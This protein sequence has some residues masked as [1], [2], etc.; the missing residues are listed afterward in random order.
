VW[1]SK[2]IGRK[3]K[4]CNAI[5]VSHFG[6]RR[7]GNKKN[8]LD[9][10]IYIVLSTQTDEAKYQSVY[11]N[12]KRR[13]RSWRK[14]ESHH[15]PEIET[16]LEPGGLSAIKADRIIS[17]LSTL[18][19]NFGARSLAMLKR[20]SDADAEKTLCSLPGVGI[21][22]ARCIM[23]YS[24]DRNVFPVDTHTFRTLDRLG[25][26]SY[27]LPVRRWHNHIQAIV[28]EDIRYSLHVTLV[29]LGREYCKATKP[30][31]KD[32]PMNELCCYSGRLTKVS[33]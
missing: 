16:I 32:C 20:M 10:L 6:L 21:K 5:L 27:P 19:I 4:K 30:N 25:A 22:T 31:C 13:F 11:S 2:E 1:T 15:K 18:D 29:S 17:I 9:E 3:L 8:P 26:H 28:P 23:M 12:L 14:I 33:G 24:L 7:H